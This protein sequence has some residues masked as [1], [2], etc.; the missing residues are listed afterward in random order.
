[1]SRPERPAFPQEEIEAAILAL[2]AARGAEKS[3]CPTDAAK[4]LHAGPDWQRLLPEVRAAAVR[5]ADGGQVVITRKGKPV[6]PKD[7]KGVYRIRA[8]E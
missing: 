1:M 5:L 8:P 4:A 7:F 6:D 2:T 3:I